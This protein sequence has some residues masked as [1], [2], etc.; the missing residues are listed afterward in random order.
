MSKR[1]C[2]S[3]WLSGFILLL[4][5]NGLA[6]QGQIVPHNKVTSVIASFANSEFVGNDKIRL[7]FRAR[8]N[9]NAAGRVRYRWIRS[10]GGA[11]DAQEINFTAAGAMVVTTSWTMGGAHSGDS[12]WEAVQIQYPNSL[13]SNKARCLVPALDFKI[14][15]L[16]NSVTPNS[17]K[18]PCPATFQA[19]S[20]ITAVGKGTA[21]YRWVRSDGGKTRPQ[22]L[23]FDGPGTKTVMTSWKL[24]NLRADEGQRRWIAVEILYPNHI[25]PSSMGSLTLATAPIPGVAVFDLVCTEIARN[26]NVPIKLE[27]SLSGMGLDLRYNCEMPSFHS[28]IGKWF[29]GKITVRNLSPNPIKLSEQMPNYVMT[30]M[31]VLVM[32]PRNKEAL[33]TKPSW[34]YV[35]NDPNWGSYPLWYPDTL[36]GHGQFDTALGICFDVYDD[37]PIVYVGAIYRDE[38]TDDRIVSNLVK[39]ETKL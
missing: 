5:P 17:W 13:E 38:P 20:Q 21:Q 8:I 30:K 1:I 3:V 15:G 4:L 19:S 23:V 37:H 26:P 14:I 25:L 2:V 9:A 28:K 18:G 29:K 34:P 36:A 16:L 12:V 33:K 27:V 7:N 11:G 22:D 31:D 6:P 24:S 35:Y 39:W 32:F 10:D